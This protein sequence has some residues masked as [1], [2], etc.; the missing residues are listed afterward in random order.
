MG[1]GFGIESRLCAVPPAGGLVS[2]DGFAREIEQALSSV[3]VAF[4]A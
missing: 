2:C 3:N 4:P 1:C